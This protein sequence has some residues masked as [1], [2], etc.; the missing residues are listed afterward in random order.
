MAEV[1]KSGTADE[2]F[3][4]GKAQGRRVYAKTGTAE[5]GVYR[6]HSLFVGFI[7]FADGT[8]L[9][10]SVIVPRSGVGAQVAGKLTEDI[11]TAIIEHENKKGNKI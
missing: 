6:D 1:V 10:F 5:T 2:L 8:P 11:L 7:T 9:V 4:K 3:K